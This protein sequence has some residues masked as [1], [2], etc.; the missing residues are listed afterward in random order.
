MPFLRR[1]PPPSPS[2]TATLTGH[3]RAVNAAGF[4][5]DGRLLASGNADKT[6]I[7]WD[8]TDPAHPAQRVTVT[9]SDRSGAIKAVGFSVD[10][11]LL[12]T[13]AADA[14]NPA[15]L[16][17]V[18]DPERPARLATIRPPGRDLGWKEIATVNA[19]GFSPGGRLL[20]VGS[21]DVINPSGNL[22]TSR[23]AVALWDV[24][25]LAH[26]VRTAILRAG[27]QV[28]AV[29]FSPDGRLLASCGTDKTARLWEVS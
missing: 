8:V 5:P 1:R 11:R 29:A 28:H 2:L 16:W 14:K 17:D 20:A 24:T 27:V 26:P 10:G 13:G 4:S 3:S 15:V 9:Q 18:A 21:G 22:P 23:G 25:D 12:A 19:V 7:L 6:V